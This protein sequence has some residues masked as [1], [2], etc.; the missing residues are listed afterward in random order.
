MH[1]DF[2]DEE[3]AM[4]A[5]FSQGMTTEVRPEISPL[6]QELLAYRQGAMVKNVDVLAYWKAHEKQYPLLAQ[7]IT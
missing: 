5:Q 6:A 4:L 3:Q 2:E 1:E 7:V